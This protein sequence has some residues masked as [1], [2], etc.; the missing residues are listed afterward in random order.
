MQ[1]NLMQKIAWL[2]FGPKMAFEKYILKFDKLPAAFNSK[3]L[4]KFLQHN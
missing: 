2:G 4:L 1:N 3:K